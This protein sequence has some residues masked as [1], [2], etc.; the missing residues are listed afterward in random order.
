M[1]DIFVFKYHLLEKMITK[2]MLLENIK[3][4]AK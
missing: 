1:M 3:K 4:V 2:N